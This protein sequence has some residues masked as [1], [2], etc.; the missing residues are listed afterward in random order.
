VTTSDRS[1][2]RCRAR[3]SVADAYSPPRCTVHQNPAPKPRSA[4]TTKG[5]NAMGRH[6]V[7]VHEGRQEHGTV[8]EPQ[9]PHH[10]DGA[11]DAAHQTDRRRPGVDHGASPGTWPATHTGLP[12]ARVAL[13]GGDATI[14][15]CKDQDQPRSPV[16][17]ATG[18]SATLP[19]GPSEKEGPLTTTT[20]TT[21]VSPRP[22]DDL[23]T[24]IHLCRRFTRCARRKPKPPVQ[25]GFSSAAPEGGSGARSWFS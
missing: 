3:P 10:H 1:S 22:R 8:D 12:D 24:V 14:R 18:H 5:R 7:V 25:H 6:T 15:V 19:I 17:R 4:A 9:R 16:D 13:W 11:Q 21:T 20:P 23:Y 2:F